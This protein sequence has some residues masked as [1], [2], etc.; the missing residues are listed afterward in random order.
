MIDWLMIEIQVT[1]P[2]SRPELATHLFSYLEDASKFWASWLP[3][4]SLSWPER[5]SWVI[6]SD[7]LF[8]LSMLLGFAD[9]WPIGRGYGHYSI[10]G[11]E[12]T[13]VRMKGP[14]RLRKPAIASFSARATL[15]V[16][17][18]HWN[19]RTLNRRNWKRSEGP[20]HTTVLGVHVTVSSPLYCHFIFEFIEIGADTLRESL[21]D[22]L[23]ALFPD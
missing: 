17:A 23:P 13:E 19:H 7:I 22:E 14:K 3:L 16:W 10:A 11:T 18:S 4:E 20:F 15:F 12:G 6:L 8:L 9:R 5:F 21:W 1:A 2:P